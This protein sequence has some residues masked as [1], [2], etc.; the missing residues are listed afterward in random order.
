MTS[1]I[2]TLIETNNYVN[3]M[4]SDGNNYILDHMSSFEDDSVFTFDRHC[5]EVELNIN[6]LDIIQ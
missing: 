2:K 5:D 4:D 3:V 6:D 1:Q